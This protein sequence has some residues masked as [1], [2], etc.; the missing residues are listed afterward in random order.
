MGPQREVSKGEWHCDAQG[1]PDGLLPPEKHEMAFYLV[2]KLALSP[3][4]D[5]G[6]AQH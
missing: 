4:E 3:K 6:W 2:E 5:I 1:T